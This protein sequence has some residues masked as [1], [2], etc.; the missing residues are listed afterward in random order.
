ML[1]HLAPTVK[2]YHKYTELVDAGIKGILIGRPR[3]I[4]G[5]EACI[6]ASGLHTCEEKKNKLLLMV[7]D[8]LRRDN[9]SSDKENEIEFLKAI[10]HH[11][12][13]NDLRYFVKE[14]NVSSAK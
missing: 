4:F 9:A 8:I 7:S 1:E 6:F 11:D 14:E 13:A 2:K 5:C 10:G 3:T 12:E